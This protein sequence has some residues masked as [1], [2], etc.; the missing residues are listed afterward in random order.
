MGC[1]CWVMKVDCEVDIPADA[2]SWVDVGL[3]RLAIFVL[4]TSIELIA[5]YGGLRRSQSSEG[6]KAL[7]E[8]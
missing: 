2:E 7:L 4:K 3:S 6:E 5:R 8:A 1:C